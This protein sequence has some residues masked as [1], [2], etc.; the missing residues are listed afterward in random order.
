MAALSSLRS[1]FLAL[2]IALFGVLALLV[3]AWVL[4]RNAEIDMQRAQLSRYQSYLLADELRQ[5]SDDLTRLAR[6]YVV[7]GDAKYEAQY[8]D[9]LAIRNGEKPRPEGYHR[10]YWDFVAGGTAKPRPDDRPVALQE[11]MRQAGFTEAEFAKLRQ[12]QANSDGLV[13]IETV[14]M[15]AVKGQFD[16]GK[17]G[18]TLKKEPDLEMARRLMHSAE[19]H[20]FKAEIMAPVDEFYVL[21]DR[22]TTEAVAEAE[23]RTVFYGR[24]VAVVLTL[25]GIFA[26]AT[27]AIL[28][29][30]V[31]RP[32]DAL[33][34][35]ML[36]LAENRHDVTVPATGRRDEIGA[37]AKAVEVFKENI[38]HI[39]ELR[40]EQAASGARAE[41][42]RR[43]ALA[44][45]AESFEAS[46][47]G[48]VR[49]VAEAASHMRANAESLSRS[50]D[51][52]AHQTGIVASA[53]QQ[54]NGNVRS[55]ADSS[56]ELSGSIR[57][58]ADRVGAATSA[59]QH[60]VRAA[61]GTSAS[62]RGLSQAAQQIGEV[63]KLISDI[64]SQTNLLALN[65]TIEAARAGEAGK[66]FAVVASEVKSL[67]TQT[68]KATEDIQS[69]VAAIQAE[70]QRAVQAISGIAGTIDDVSRIT[71]EIAS[72]V[73]QQDG[74]TRE[75]GRNV[76]E[77]AS[78][79]SQVSSTIVDVARMARETGG[80]AEQ[81]LST[82][83][84]LS[85]LA[86]RL[87]REV[88]GFIVRI[89]AG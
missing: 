78:G 51:Q 76:Q 3:A 11:L 30:G 42:E 8:W 36:A 70:T 15:N 27:T 88:D 33:K 56:T 89:R 55:V 39:A 23:A 9:V 61:E 53:A 80:S 32:I 28:L 35:A 77:A 68:A 45:I 81:V 54:A 84:N 18:F 64:A 73:E 25:L 62:V 31:L 44:R 71:G 41:A 10:I 12:A 13:K 82:A 22:R 69:Q 52:A 16:D 20:K 74:A 83:S 86:D 21:L 72:T 46:V 58:M 34:A 14:A 19:Y 59:A 67:A 2:N 4:F 40:E 5:S 63:V 65:A 1:R 85:D 24:A 43:A 26:V 6:T 38:H 37:M 75:I 7:T 29:R 87:S 79:T 49:S 57:A 66:G 60:A 17:G 48:V 50:A 47:R